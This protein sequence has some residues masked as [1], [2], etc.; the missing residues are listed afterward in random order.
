LCLF[1]IFSPSPVNLRRLLTLREAV[2]D[3]AGLVCA[4]HEK[5]YFFPNRS[6]AD[7]SQSI[8]RGSA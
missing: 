1:S 5:H 6:L 3:A 4:V 8:N 2:G 7:D